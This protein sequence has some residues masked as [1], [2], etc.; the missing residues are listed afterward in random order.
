MEVSVSL[1]RNGCYRVYPTTLLKSPLANTR[2]PDSRVGYHAV[3]ADRRAA[4]EGT[5]SMSE[6]IFHFECAEAQLAVEAAWLAARKSSAARDNLLATEMII[7]GMAI[8]RKVD[9]EVV[10]EEVAAGIRS[11]L[12]LG[13]SLTN[14]MPKG[15]A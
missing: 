5:Y 11:G 10:R 1:F 6:H 13:P 4:P 2:A 7:Q 12:G 15:S 8:L 14:L 3:A 9:A